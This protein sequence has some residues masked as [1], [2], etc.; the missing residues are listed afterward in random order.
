M[1][2][3]WAVI[4]KAEV[5]ALQEANQVKKRSLCVLSRCMST[6]NACSSPIPNPDSSIF[7][8]SVGSIQLHQTSVVHARRLPPLYIHAQ[9]DE[10]VF[11]KPRTRDVCVTRAAC[12]YIT[13]SLSNKLV[14]WVPEFVYCLIHFLRVFS[15][16]LVRI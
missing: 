10:C 6:F 16:A 4:L 2:M 12:R 1:M 13:S 14:I 11:P 15:S 7:H 3:H 5:K 9:T 8:M